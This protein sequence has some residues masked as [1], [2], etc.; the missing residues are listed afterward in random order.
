MTLSSLIQN[1]FQTL[2]QKDD[3]DFNSGE[4]AL[5]V[6]KVLKP[7]LNLNSYRQKLDNLSYELEKR[8]QGLNLRHAPL[9]AKVEAL[10]SLMCKDKGFHGDEE[11]YDDLDHMNIAS[12]IDHK[13]GTALCLSLL[14]LHCAKICGWATFGINFPGY[15]LI[16]LEDG[17]KRAI[18][19]PFQGCVE[20]DAYTLRQMIKVLGGAEAELQPLFYDPL[21]PKTLFIRH[22]GA[23]K[24]H[25]LRCEQI[26]QA[27]EILEICHILEPVSPAFWRD[28]GLLHA[29]IGQ[30][31]EAITALKNA[32]IHTD[33]PDAIRHTQRI[34]SDLENKV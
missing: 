8:Y 18:L 13:C 16:C 22:L 4:A 32:L 21:S 6:A 33:D 27:L 2:S 28:S 9:K 20:L 10:Q 31:D 3:A 15:S 29:R 30:L 26:E 14:F 17:A 34:L 25:F 1:G 5:L 24:A 19:D 23:I 7:S 11:A 12:L